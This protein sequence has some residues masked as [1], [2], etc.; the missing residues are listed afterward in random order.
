MVKTAFRASQI[1]GE[2]GINDKDLLAVEDDFFA[3]FFSEQEI[4][5]MEI[6]VRD[7]KGCKILPGLVDS[8]IHGALGFDTMDAVPESLQKIGQYLLEKGTTSWMPTT[9]TATIDDICRAIK[10]VN[11]CKNKTN[12][13]AARIIGCF[14]EGPYITK[15]HKGAHP[16]ELIRPLNK[17]EVKKM[18][19]AGPIRAL[20]VAP[21]KENALDFIQWA[22][23]HKIKISLA[24]SS[25]E[26]KEA[27]L[28][29]EAGADAVVHTFCGM[30]SLHHRKPN[31][32]GAA[33]IVDEIYAELI[34]DGIHVQAPAM[35][36]L[37]RCKPNNR[38]ILVSD[39][40]QATGL[41]D[42]EYM[43]GVEPIMVQNG[44]SRIKTGSLAGSTTTL[45]DEVRLLIQELGE[46]PLIAVHMASLNPSR[47]FGLDDKIGSI[48]KGKKADFIIVDENYQLKETWL[49]GIN[50]VGR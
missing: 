30:S 21:E 8:H 20:A 31:L 15:E 50:V 43:L 6:S 38:V 40:I 32:L 27:C 28:A 41:A 49:N 14:V 22:V 36:I 47:R 7:Y 5:D 45:L 10:N 3:G 18:L 33:L 48:R 24:H 2:N 35:K 9:V 42:G 46:S 29:I 12:D 26:F 13:T 16:E 4:A 25:A 39:A 34:A 23:Q 19:A 1:F 11:I 17:E 44:I 37:L